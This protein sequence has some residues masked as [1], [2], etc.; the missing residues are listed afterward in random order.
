MFEICRATSIKNPGFIQLLSQ[1]LIERGQGVPDTAMLDQLESAVRMDRI[2]F[3]MALDGDRV[4]G[5][6]S[7]T[8]S[9]S[10]MNMCPYAV[11]GD[12]YVHPGH[13]GRGCAAVLL[14]GAMDG[15]HEAGCNRIIT[16]RY[17]GMEGIF[18]RYGWYKSNQLMAYKVKL[19]QAPPSLTVTG[20]ITFD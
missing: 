9:F 3:Y 5:V 8:V 19:D 13:R 17:D 18:D 4:V 2:R 16:E 10:T 6:I 1:F 15:A 20:S 12:L 7:L 14:M 11:L